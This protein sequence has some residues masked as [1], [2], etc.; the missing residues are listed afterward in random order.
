MPDKYMKVGDTLPELTATLEV[1]ADDG[2][3]SA[4]NIYGASVELILRPVRSTEPTLH[5]WADNLDNDVGGTNRGMVRYSWQP[6][7]TDLPGGYFGEWR[8]TYAAGDVETFPDTGYFT[9]AI[10]DNLPAVGS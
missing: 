2:T 3:T 8:V 9:L 1:T 10:L 5:V 7:D 6:G 4:A